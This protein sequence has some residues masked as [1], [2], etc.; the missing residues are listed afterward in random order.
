[1][2]YHKLKLLLR[3]GCGAQL[4]GGDRRGD[5]R[6]D[7]RAGVARGHVGFIVVVAEFK[8]LLDFTVSVLNLARPEARSG[9]GRG[10]RRPSGPPLPEARHQHLSVLVAAATQVPHRV[11]EATLRE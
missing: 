5:G 4:R 9:R 3:G 11:A 8:F 10:G 7:R 1:M 2:L 6:R